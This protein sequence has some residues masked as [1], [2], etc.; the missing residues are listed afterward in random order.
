MKDS[1][2]LVLQVFKTPWAKAQFML[3]VLRAHWESIVG[4][5]AAPPFPALP[6]GGGRFIYSHGSSHLVCS[7]DDDAGKIAVTVESPVGGKP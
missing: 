5:A 3:H 1:E 7:F 2:K 4:P 6:A